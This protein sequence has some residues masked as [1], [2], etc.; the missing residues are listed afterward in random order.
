MEVIITEWGLQ[1]YLDLVGGGVITRDDYWDILRPDVEKL[2][3]FPQHIDFSNSKFW[4]PATDRG[5]NNIVNGY[6]MK[7][8]N[9]GPGR[10]QLRLSVAI[11]KSRA[12]LCRAYAKSSDA[13]DKREAAKLK[14]HI[15][16]IH[17]GRHQER[18]FL[19]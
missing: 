12:Y 8:H 11:L 18:G 2:R 6:K 19:P 9:M 17:F 14:D 13:K 3:L 15:Q 4:G 1:A 16:D 7:W 10:V 5:G